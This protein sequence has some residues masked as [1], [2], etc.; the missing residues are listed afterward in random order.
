MREP[1]VGMIRRDRSERPGSEA[2]SPIIEPSEARAEFRTS[3]AD[4]VEIN[5]LSGFVRFNLLHHCVEVENMNTL[6]PLAFENRTHLG[7]KEPQL[8]PVH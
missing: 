3:S 8:P 2:G 7:F 6:R 1:M 5:P 4:R